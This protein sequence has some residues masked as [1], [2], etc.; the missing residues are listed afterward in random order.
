MKVGCEAPPFLKGGA[1][2]KSKGG[3]TKIR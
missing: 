2:N 1:N 3:A